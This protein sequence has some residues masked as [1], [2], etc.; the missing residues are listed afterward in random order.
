MM[1][2]L[3]GDNAQIAQ[4]LQGHAKSSSKFEQISLHQSHNQPDKARD[5]LY[6]VFYT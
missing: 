2:D 5:C 3:V 1:R 4:G 6:T